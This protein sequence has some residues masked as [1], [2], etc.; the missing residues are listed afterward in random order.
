[1]EILPPNQWALHPSWTNENR[2]WFSHLWK[3]KWESLCP[4]KKRGRFHSL[5]KIGW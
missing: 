2:K 3:L 5:I 4:M 1:L